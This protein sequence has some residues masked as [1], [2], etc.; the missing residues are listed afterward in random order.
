MHHID[1]IHPYYVIQER[2]FGFLNFDLRNNGETLVGTFYNTD[3]LG[4]IDKFQISKDRT[5]EKI[6]SDENSD[7]YN[8]K[9]FSYPEEKSWIFNN[10]IHLT[11]KHATSY[12]MQLDS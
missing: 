9:Y 12:K 5:G 1:F 10:R 11:D 7:E 4:I 3:N 6:Y 2:Y 8:N